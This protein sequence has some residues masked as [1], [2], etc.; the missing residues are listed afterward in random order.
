MEGLLQWYTVHLKCCP[1]GIS[2]SHRTV[3][4]YC[5]SHSDKIVQFIIAKK[6]RKRKKKTIRKEGN[7]FIY[8]Y[9]VS[10]QW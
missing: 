5:A 1:S 6:E 8:G 2:S 9:M 3:T 7:V 10:A 4:N